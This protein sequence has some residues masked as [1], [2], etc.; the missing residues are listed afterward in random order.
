[1]PS[2]ARGTAGSGVAGVSRRGGE[3]GAD[4]WGPL[5]R[6]KRENATSLDGAN[7]KGKHISTETPLTH[8]PD[9]LARKASAY[10]EGRPTGLAGPKAKWACKDSWAES[11][12]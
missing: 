7:R 4:R 8:G 1:V 6:E 12:K 10:G 2:G 5:D 11:E 3:E 9:G